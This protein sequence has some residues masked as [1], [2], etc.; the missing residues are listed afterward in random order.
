LW[1]VEKHF[2]KTLTNAHVFVFYW[3][4]TENIPKKMLTNGAPAFCSQFVLF[5]TISHLKNLVLTYLSSP[6]PKFLLLQ[7][8][9]RKMLK[10]QRLP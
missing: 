6:Y 9:T 8:F 7:S 2:K 5:P 4:K 3:I 1:H 10:C